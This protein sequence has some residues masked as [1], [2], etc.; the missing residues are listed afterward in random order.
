M[1]DPTI[2]R[3]PS[4]HRGRSPSDSG[5]A[6]AVAFGRHGIG[7]PAGGT[8]ADVVGDVAAV[9]GTVGVLS[10][11]EDEGG[12]EA[13]GEQ[14][15]RKGEEVHGCDDVMGWRDCCG[16]GIEDL[17]R[18]WLGFGN[19]E[20]WVEEREKEMDGIESIYTRLG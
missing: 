2:K 12:R 17:G 3:I 13:G 6:P 15:K 9:L 16:G 20:R 10:W 1:T 7:G 5:P 19:C 4:P 14:Q 11:L 8:L 18:R